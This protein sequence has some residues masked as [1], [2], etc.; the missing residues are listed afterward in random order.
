MFDLT[1]T[2]TFDCY[3]TLVDWERG[4]LDVV[5]PYL[6][7]HGHYPDDEE[8]LEIYA[9][10]EAAAETG[11]Y[12]PY[13]K[14][15]R[16][17]MRGFGF[18][19]QFS[20]TKEE[21]YKLEEALPAWPL[22]PDTVDGLR[23][24]GRKYRLAIISNI[25]NDLFAGTREA[26]DVPFDHVITAEDVGAYKPSIKNFRRALTVIGEEPHKIL[27][28]AQSVYH[29]IVPARAMGLSTVWVDRRAGKEGSGATPPV[30]EM[31][32]TE[33]IAEAAKGVYPDHRVT[34]LFMLCN[35]L[36]VA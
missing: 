14:I 34:D 6:A 13:R 3:G 2:I 1:T 4:I 17:V 23:R 36:G 25:D 19:Y 5:K 21:I 10:E 31:D 26:L 11:A 27:H 16:Q 28:V 7:A 33:R 12:L 22:F 15:L 35:I 24:L 30:E 20:H 32:E 18:H 8:I 9:K 29:D